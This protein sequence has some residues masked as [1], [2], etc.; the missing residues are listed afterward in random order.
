MRGA[1]RWWFSFETASKSK[2]RLLVQLDQSWTRSETWLVLVKSQYVSVQ[3]I[4]TTRRKSPAI[5]LV[6]CSVAAHYNTC[7]CIKIPDAH[8]VD[9]PSSSL[10]LLKDIPVQRTTSLD[11]ATLVFP[12]PQELHRTGHNPIPA[13]ITS[14]LTCN[15][16][17]LVVT[18]VSQ[19]IRVQHTP[20][21]T[22]LS[23]RHPLGT[24]SL[25]AF[26]SAS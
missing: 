21:A 23:Y 3:S 18:Q 17:P 5:F 20:T 15:S 7:Q 22:S 10:S 4:S 11:L 9:D 12:P 19:Q 25:T 16:S 26:E 24:Q 13:I 2:F 8:C 14:A 6:S 1:R